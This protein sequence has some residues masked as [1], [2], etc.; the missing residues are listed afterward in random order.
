[1]VVTCWIVAFFARC[2]LSSI[3]SEFYACNSLILPHNIIN[4]S[5]YI[6][7][8]YFLFTGLRTCMKVHNVSPSKV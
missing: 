7:G 3:T 2:E 6:W 8:L 4:E 1:M 5:Q